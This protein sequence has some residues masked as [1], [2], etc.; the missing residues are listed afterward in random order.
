MNEQLINDQY[1]AIRIL[2]GQKRLKEALVQLEAYLWHISDW[3]LSTRLEQVQTSY[4]YMLQYMQQGVTDPERK[5]LHLKLLADT[6]EIADQVRLI[7]LDGTSARYYH[8]CRRTQAEYPSNSLNKLVHILESFNDDLAV[9]ELLSETKVEKVMQCHE[10]AQKAIYLQTWTNSAWTPAEEAIAHDMLQSES[11]PVND[12]CMFT[13][14]VMLS[15]MECFDL[16]KLMWLMDAYQ[17]KDVQISQRALV[18]MIFVFHT[19]AC[20]LDFYP[21]VKNRIELLNEELPVGEDITR[22]YKQ[23]LLCQD[24]EK[25]NKK[26]REEIIPE[27]LKSASSMRNMKF[28]FEEESDEEKDDQNPD[29]EKAFENSGL[30]NKLREI[31]ELQMEGGDVYMST[32]SALKNFPFF[33]EQNHWFYP[34]DTQH[35]AIRNMLKG[36]VQKGSMLELI[37]GS[38]FFCNSDKYS[39]FFTMQQIPQ[40]HRDMMLSQ[41]TDQQMEEISDQSKADTLKKYSERPATVSSQY[42]HDLYRF[43]KLNT[44]RHEFLDIFKENIYLHRIPILKDI[45]S[46]VD[47]LSNLAE[48]HHQKGHW[49]EAAALYKEI[50]QLNEETDN[51]GEFYQKL[52]YALQKQKKYKKAIEAYLKAD[53]IK[54]DTAWTNQHLALCYRMNRDYDKA[55]EYYRKI[56]AVV[57]ENHSVLF[58]AGSCLAELEQY[59]EAMKYFFK[60]DFLEN[61][62]MKAWRGIGWCSFVTGKYEQ[63]I[64]YYNKVIGKDPQTVDYL[65]IGHATWA[66]GNIEEAVHLY[67]KAMIASKNKEQF[68]ELFYKDKNELI[69]QGIAKDDIPL[70]LDLL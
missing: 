64:K 1:V 7:M 31:N 50:E 51:Q 53:T 17:H 26:M 67:A 65:N 66:M 55:L 3:S 29:W 18:G 42:M 6:W 63:A 33:R 9:N 28:G 25:I 47:I 35:S 45:L 30:N 36:E 44:R 43:F 22:I 11:L 2:I 37:L 58:Y 48:F 39:L 23:L 10:D 54:P 46:R 52:G 70:M 19:C 38:G 57:P 27:M 62:S 21:E 68:L 69:K 4:N 24:T 20:R 49:V 8:I 14:A 61:D 15:I 13:S 41:L 12:L 59:E 56:E 16:R 5:K 40:A 32:F 34:F 60:L